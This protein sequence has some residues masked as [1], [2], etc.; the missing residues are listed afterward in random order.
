[1]DGELRL[2]SD[3]TPVLD[4]IFLGESEGRLVAAYW[5]S[6]LLGRVW[7][8]AEAFAR[9]LRRPPADVD[10]SAALQFI[11]RVEALS[12]ET[13]AIEAAEHAM[14]ARLFDLYG[15]TAAER[16]LVEKARAR[17]TWT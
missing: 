5:R 10:T 8:D 2:L 4:R 6:L 13:A 1:M 12:A 9:A 17:R 16:I 14:D 15:L 3:G 11:A 7:R